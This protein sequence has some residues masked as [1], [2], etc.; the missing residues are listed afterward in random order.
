MFAPSIPQ[1]QIT[2]PEMS[3]ILSFFLFHW[4]NHT[5]FAMVPLRFDQIIT[6]ISSYV[7]ADTKASEETWYMARSALL[8]A[9]GCAIETIHFSTECVRIIGP[10]V[11]ETIVPNGFRL[12]GT[13]HQLDPAKGAF[14][15]GA[16]IRYLD[17]ND[18]YPGKEWGHPSGR[19]SSLL[20]FS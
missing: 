20:E 18:A 11:P 3:T 16:L 14:D 2:C 8:D 1:P 10:V 12:P 5:I 6:D 19:F 7:H 17:H 4:H 9:I 15:L 13:S